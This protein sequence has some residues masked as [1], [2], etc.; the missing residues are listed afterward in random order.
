M[1][2]PLISIIVPCYNVEQYLQKC[3]DSIMAQTYQNLEILLVD[4]GSLDNSGIICDK[5]SAKDKRIIVIHKENGGQSDARN[6]ALDVMTGE[7]V[8]FIDS[9]DYVTEDYVETLYN[10]I[11]KFNAQVSVSQ[12]HIFKEGTIP[13][14]NSKRTEEKCFTSVKA[15]ENMF[16]QK[17]ETGPCVKMYHRSLF[18]SGIRYPKGVIFED[19]YTI[20]KVLYLAEKIAYS[21][22][23]IYY[24]QFR[25]NSTEGAEF[26]QVKMDS[27]LKV[28]DSME[29]HSEIINQVRNAYNCRMLSFTF[30]LLLKMP[31]NY[32]HKDLL[33]SKIKKYRWGVLFDRRARKKARLACLISFLGLRAMKV[34]F[35][36]ID[37]RKH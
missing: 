23:E 24:Y 28:Y 16:Y 27:A 25:S 19:L 1:T 9:D 31:H 36:F 29:S 21:N 8:T 22:K 34:I 7:Y 20:Y 6:V 3:I 2:K 5:Y 13:K 37:I 10:L 11:I 35:S 33:L 26:S 4:D 12:W 30:H 15:I 18:D 32:E 17:F 14:I